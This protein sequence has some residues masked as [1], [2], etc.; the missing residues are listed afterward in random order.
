MYFIFVMK[1]IFAL[2]LGICFINSSAQFSIVQEYAFVQDVDGFLNVRKEGELKSKI[3]DKLENGQLIYCLENK[4]NWMSIDYTKN[5]K[6]LMGFVYK[7]RY[8]L[9]SKFPQIPIR[10]NSINSVVLRKDSIQIIVSQSK[11][12][13]SKHS[14]KYIKKYSD[15]IQLIDNKQYWGRDGG[16]PDTQYGKIEI[17]VGNKIIS[18]PKLAFEGLYQP[19]IFTVQVNFDNINDTFYINTM[20]SD[21]AGGYHVLWRVEKGV[22]KDRLIVY[23]F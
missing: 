10:S 5:K 2:L 4:G 9:I 11:F 15:Q 19:N 18:L 13:K 21:G 3:I 6:L 14:F 22:Y 16:M 17:K 1:I 23:G 7:N 12:D 20:N 8:K